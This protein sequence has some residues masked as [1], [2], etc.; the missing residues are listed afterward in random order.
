MDGY[1]KKEYTQYIDETDD[2]ED[3]WEQ[4]QSNVKYTFL[5]EEEFDED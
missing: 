3:D 4:S 2:E 1:S 5:K